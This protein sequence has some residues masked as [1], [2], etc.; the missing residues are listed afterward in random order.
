[1]MPAFPP[2][3]AEVLK[4]LARCIEALGPYQSDAVLS[5]GLVPVMYRRVLGC[6]SAIPPRNTFDLDW[7][8]PSPLVQHEQGLHERMLSMGFTAHHLRL[9]NPMSF[10]VQK[11]LIRP[12]RDSRKQESDLC[13]V[14]DVAILTHDRWDD[15][16]TMQRQL[17]EC[18]FPKS[19]VPKARTTLQKLF[20]SSTSPGPLAVSRQHP[21]VVSEDDAVRGIAAFMAECWTR[22]G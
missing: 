21:G 13:H 12:R 6:V 2:E 20:A 11:T 4:H 9:P 15:L 17:E 3:F 1:M 10:I 16:R 8:L 14:Y 5:G 7:T 18:G 19:W 22:H